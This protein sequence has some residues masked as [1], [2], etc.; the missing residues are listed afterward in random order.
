MNGAAPTRVGFCGM[1]TMGSAMAANLCRAGFEVRVWNRTPGRAGL[2]V[3]L[4]AI[5]SPDP[6]TLASESDV[7]VICV[8][9]TPDVTE[10][11]FGDD[12]VADGAQS[13][14]LVIDCSRSEEH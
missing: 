11:L 1:G 5:E 4:G 10:V 9:D 6:V 7:V 12:G 3:S 13:G 14:S 2:P 8:S